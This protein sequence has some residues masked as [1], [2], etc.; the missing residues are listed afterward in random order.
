MGKL[1]NQHLCRPPKMRCFVLSV[2]F[3]MQIVAFRLRC[4]HN[5]SDLLKLFLVNNRRYFMSL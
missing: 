1:G 3:C 2:A 5:L 4:D